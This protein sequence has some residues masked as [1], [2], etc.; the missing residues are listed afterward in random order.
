LKSYT[1]VVEKLR[2]ELQSQMEKTN[3]YVL[4]AFVN[5]A[6]KSYLNTWMQNQLDEATVR[7]KTIKWKRYKN[8]SGPT[9]KNKAL[10]SPN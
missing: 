2:K 8:K 5:R 9:K 4:D 6:D 3:D 10:Y 7:R 1:I